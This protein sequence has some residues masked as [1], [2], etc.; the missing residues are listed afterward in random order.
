MMI[1]FLLFFLQGTEDQLTY[2]LSYLSIYHNIMQ[3]E[4]N[5]HYFINIFQ[6]PWQAMPFLHASL[7]LLDGN[8]QLW[9][10]CQI[11]ERSLGF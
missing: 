9:D 6:E 2:A 5:L 3:A 11:Q 8:M 4:A 10:R 7:P 1:F